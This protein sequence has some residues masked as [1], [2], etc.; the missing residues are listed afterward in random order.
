MRKIIL[1][2]YLL[3]L[4]GCYLANGS[5]SSFK[6]WYAPENINE[7]KQEKIW[8]DC[9]DMAY[10]ILDSNQK[11]ILDRGKVS[12]ETVYENK[13]EYKILE[14]AIELHQRYLFQC[15][16]NSGFRFR[17]PLYWCLAQDGDNTRTCI[18]NMK[19]RN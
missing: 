3:L 8:N 5:P 6:Y 18:E 14:D 12:W 4:S 2:F 11:K 13:D 9:S 16:Y 7:M 17:P 15:L 19:Y 10:S 1:L